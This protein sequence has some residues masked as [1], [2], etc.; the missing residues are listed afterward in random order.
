FQIS[1]ND[2]NQIMTILSGN[3]TNGANRFDSTLVTYLRQIGN[4]EAVFNMQQLGWF[5][6]DSWKVN[7]K[8][9]IDLGLRWELQLNPR[10][11]GGNQPLIDRVNNIR[12]P[13]SQLARVDKINDTLDQIM[14]R[15]G[16]AYSPFGNRRMVIRGFSGVFYGATPMLSFSGPTNNFRIPPGDV[17]IQVGGAGTQLSVYQAFLQA[18]VNLNNFPL[19]KLPIIPVDVVQR[20]SAIALG[21]SARD[22]F[23]GAN[24]VAMASD[25]R[26]P[27]SMQSGFGVE[28]EVFRNFTAGVQFNVVNTVNLIRNRDYNLPAPI[29]LTGDATQR[30]NIGIRN[31]PGIRPAVPRPVST[32]GQ[33]TVRESSARSMYRSA[34]VTLQYRTKKLQLQGFYTL[35]ENFSDDDNERDTGGTVAENQFNYLR[36]YNYSLL[37]SRHQF[38]GNGVYTLPWGFEVGGI[39][40]YR[41]GLPMNPRT[42]NDENQDNNFTDRPTIAPGVTMA[43]NSFRNRSF[44]TT[45]L[46]VMKNFGVGEGKKIQFSVE[47]F[48][49]FNA[50]NVAFVN[51]SVNAIYGPGLLPNGTTAPVDPR[52][53]RLRLPDG[54][55]D[56]VNQQVGSPLQV[57]GALRFFF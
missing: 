28:S 25:F 29:L 39:I 7:S 51:T 16:L 47:F 54:R 33:L 13:N 15:F 43:R 17:S 31:A 36:D 49:L 11:Q 3:G 6:Q 46:R 30:P 48:N 20:A 18:G 4:L 42:G 26:N 5:V 24:V 10:F 50:D 14:P 57:Q 53:Q 1:G 19:D 8:L 22:P 9:T 38:T 44:T 12:F 32:V 21:G 52:F 23:I 2:R 37:D 56:P 27:R 55:Y 41:S 35:S 45:D 40:R 34:V